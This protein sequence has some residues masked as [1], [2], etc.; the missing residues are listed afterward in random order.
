MWPFKVTQKC[1]D[2]V[3]IRELTVQTRIMAGAYLAG[4]VL[5]KFGPDERPKLL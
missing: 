1:D 5:H 4:R 3:P 2:T